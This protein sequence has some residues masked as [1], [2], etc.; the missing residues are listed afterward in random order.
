MNRGKGISEF[1]RLKEAMPLSE[2]VILFSRFLK[3]RGFK[4]FSSSVVDALKSIEGADV[5]KREDF[6]HALRANLVT[7]DMEWKLF[8]ELFEEFWQEVD[9]EEQ[10]CEDEGDEESTD[11]AK[12]EWNKIQVEFQARDG[13]CLK[14]PTKED[15]ARP[16][17]YSPVSGLERK[18]FSEI[19]KRDIQT[20]Q[21]VLKNIMSPFKTVVRRRYRRSKRPGDIDF[22]RVMRSSLKT[23]GIPL[24]IFFRKKKKRLKRLVVMADVSGS[25]DRYARFVMP[26]IMGLKEVGSRVEVF[27]FST[28]LTP[29]TPI[30]RRYD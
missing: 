29:I 3:E 28:S 1:H 5:C 17:T 23:G 21:L 8:P 18:N 30:L 20:A 7:N 2:R 15:S 26:F 16:A 22:H 9:L 25:M 19:P 4:V 12:E 14:D 27:V 13:V 24:E 6:F 11:R 10:E